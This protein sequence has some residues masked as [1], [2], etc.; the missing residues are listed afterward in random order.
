MKKIAV[1]MFAVLMVF[2]ALPGF[3]ATME[4]SIDPGPLTGDSDILV[5]TI[6]FSLDGGIVPVCSDD[7]I[8]L[9]LVD[10]FGLEFLWGDSPGTLVDGMFIRT[11]DDS[12]SVSGSFDIFDV[13]SVKPISY[14][15][16]EDDFVGFDINLL[17]QDH[18]SF[19]PPVEGLGNSNPFT[20]SWDLS[21]LD[22]SRFAFNEILVTASYGVDAFGIGVIKVDETPRYTLA[23]CIVD[24]VE[25]D[26]DR[27]LGIK[28]LSDLQSSP[29]DD[30][31]FIYTEEE[32]DHVL[33]I[34]IQ[35]WSK[36]EID[37]ITEDCDTLNLLADDFLSLASPEDIGV[38]FPLFPLSVLNE[39]KIGS[40]TTLFIMPCSE[41]EVAQTVGGLN[42]SFDIS[43]GDKGTLSINLTEEDNSVPPNTGSDGC[44]VGFLSPFAA[45]LLLPLMFM[46]KK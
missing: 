31:N 42:G 18:V 26:I 35:N 11:T 21:G 25:E 46:R 1:L 45:L 10:S 44:S 14:D 7:K 15:I 41:P 29:D 3:A 23:L 24:P 12:G 8:N 37:L 9:D 6:D 16:Y 39:K 20:V 22:T 33:Y 27:I 36:D 5:G 4:T 30:L 38:T 32:K 34:V 13:A 28:T 43:F 40:G 17:N 2:V 19:D